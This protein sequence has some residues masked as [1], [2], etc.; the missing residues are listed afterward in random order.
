MSTSDPSGAHRVPSGPAAQINDIDAAA[1]RPARDESV[2]QLLGELSSDMSTLVRQEVALAQ[3][4]LKQKAR[5]AGKG[6]GMLAGAAVMGLAVLGALT[7]FLIIAVDRVAPLWVAALAVTVLWALIT[8]GL[9]IA[10]RGALKRA[11]PAKPEQTVE[12]VK[13]DVAWAKNQAK[14]VRK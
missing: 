14:S 13:E 1:Q 3:A 11:M 10:G 8:A 9:A 6:A 2:G 4:E 5:T 7:A 12:T